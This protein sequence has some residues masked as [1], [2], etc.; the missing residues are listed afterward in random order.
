[1]SRSSRTAPACGICC[2]AASPCRSTWCARCA[3]VWA[4]CA[5]PTAMAPPRRP[6]P[7]PS[8]KST[9]RRRAL[10][11]CRSAARSRTCAAMCSM[12]PCSRCRLGVVG[13]LYI[14]GVGLSSGYLNRPELT[15]ERFVADPLHPGRQLYRS[16][17]L[18]RHRAR[19]R[20]AVRRPRRPAGE[21]PRPA[22]RAR[23]DRGHDCCA[24]TGV[25]EAAVV[26]RTNAIGE[27]ELVAYVVSRY[28]RAARAA[29]AAAP[30]AARDDVARRAGVAA[31]AAAAAQRQARLRALP[32][33]PPRPTRRQS[34]RR[35]P[36]SSARCMTSGASCC[37]RHAFSRHD[38]FFDLRRPLTD[39]HPAGGPHPRATWA[40]TCH[41][42]VCSS[43]PPSPAWPRPCRLRPRRRRQPRRAHPSNRAAA[44]SALLPL[45]HSQQRMWLVQQM[46]PQ[47]AAYHMPFAARI[48]RRRSTAGA[49]RGAL[50]I[51]AAA[52]RGAAHQPASGAWMY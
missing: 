48:A 45:S 49:A 17:D 29:R 18:A 7:P 16:G 32:D 38:N 51:M 44:R 36:T 20:A 3:H 6:P 11:L 23:G 15:A 43:T 25:Q 1:M 35:A 26:A 40:P 46:D 37:A 9:P 19:W 5:S 4:R 52:P 13:E 2:S 22:R 50:R 41:C 8:T 34:M 28:L 27:A 24:V 14:G 42:A 33:G 30:V 12:P 47:G 10:A 31:G 21:D 39:R